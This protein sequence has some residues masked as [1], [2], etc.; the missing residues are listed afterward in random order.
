MQADEAI[1]LAL[2]DAVLDGRPLEP[3]L[4][5]SSTSGRARDLIPQ[6][7]GRVRTD[8]ARTLT[9]EARRPP[10]AT[11]V[12]C[13]AALPPQSPWGPLTILEPIGSGSFGDVYRALDPRL[14]RPWP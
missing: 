9:A 3:V 2:A 13:V 10:H 4:A 11:A 8:G 7:P 6:F 1:L 14:D 5:G 12:Q